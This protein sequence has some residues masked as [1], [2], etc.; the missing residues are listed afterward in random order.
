MRSHMYTCMCTNATSI[1]A[2]MHPC[3]IHVRA[4]VH[5][6]M[7]VHWHEC[8]LHTHTHTH[9]LW[10]RHPAPRAKMMAACNWEHQHCTWEQCDIMSV[11]HIFLGETG[12]CCSKH[13]C[14]CQRIAKLSARTVLMRSIWIFAEHVHSAMCGMILFP[15]GTKSRNLT[16]HYR[17]PIIG[18]VLVTFVLLK[19]TFCCLSTFLLSGLGNKSLEISPNTLPALSKQITIPNFVAK[20][21]TCPIVIA[22][23][24]HCLTT[25]TAG[26]HR[27]WTDQI[28]KQTSW[29]WWAVLNVPP[30]RACE[31]LFWS[32][33]ARWSLRKGMEWRP[34]SKPR[35]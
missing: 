29:H 17:S 2:S 33:G 23:S 34:A 22:Y 25:C 31:H 16:S 35:D 8:S 32:A 4:C 26:M 21:R 27:T 5:T 19:D 9:T 7:H 1:Y 30:Q 18:L 3:C 14:W 12:R 24:S 10:A 6:C 11:T 28:P 20:I 15:P 13:W